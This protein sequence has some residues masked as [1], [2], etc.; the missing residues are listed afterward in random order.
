MWGPSPVASI[1]GTKY[2]VTFIDDFSRKFWVY[3]LKQKIRS[4]SEV[5]GVE[6]FGEKSDGAEGE[7]LV[8]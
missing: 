4:R 1:G 8:V 2:Y 6:N 7:S 3:F 5:Q